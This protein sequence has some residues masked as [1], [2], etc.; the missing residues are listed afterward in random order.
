MSSRTMA[1]HM[2]SAGSLAL[3]T[4]ILLHATTQPAYAY[5]D[6]GT[7]SMVI[8]V[9][10]GGLAAILVMTRRLWEGTIQRMRRFGRP[11][12]PPPEQE[13]ARPA[14]TESRE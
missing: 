1:S 9:I 11:P 12:A 7:S 10:V 8:Q 2:K 6:P 13:T 14:P 5:I 3:F 4:A